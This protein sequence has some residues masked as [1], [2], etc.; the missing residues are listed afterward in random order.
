MSCSTC[1]RSSSTPTCGEPDL[2][3]YA[4]VLVHAFEGNPTFS[5]RDDEAEE[6]WRVVEPV[7]EAWARDEVPMVEY[8]VGS[9][10]PPARG[11]RGPARR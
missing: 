4:N 3:A 7:I 2:P 8:E 11:Q 1:H 6:A 5:I 10:G 9:S